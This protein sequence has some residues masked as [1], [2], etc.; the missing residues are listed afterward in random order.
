MWRC[1]PVPY[2]PSP[3][4]QLYNTTMELYDSEVLMS[5]SRIELYNGSTLSVGGTEGG[6]RVGEGSQVRLLKY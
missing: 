4:R 5:Y 6:R 1:P 3:V 2:H